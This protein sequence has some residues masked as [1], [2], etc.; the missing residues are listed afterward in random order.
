MTK[1]EGGCL[2]GAVTYRAEIERVAAMSCYCKDCQ[3]ATG[4]ACAT[5]VMVPRSDFAEE[6]APKSFTKKGDSGRDVTRYFCADC[7]SQLYSEVETM[8]GA[9]FVKVGTLA[10]ADELAPRTHIWTASRPAWVE[11]PEGVACFD[12]NPG[13]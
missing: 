10:D 11:L 2:C 6:G 3:R 12:K 9:V 1:I 7:G 8:P 4:S 5:F 13:G